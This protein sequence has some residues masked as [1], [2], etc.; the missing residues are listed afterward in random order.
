M[1]K[2]LLALGMCLLAMTQVAH[3]NSRLQEV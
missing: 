2:T 3:A 1:K